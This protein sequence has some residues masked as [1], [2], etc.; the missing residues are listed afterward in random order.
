MN[1]KCKHKYIVSFNEAIRKVFGSKWYGSVRQLKFGFGLMSF[2]PVILK[3]KL[4]LAGND[5]WKAC[6]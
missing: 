6:Y 4:R 3:A 5:I 2:D 1:V